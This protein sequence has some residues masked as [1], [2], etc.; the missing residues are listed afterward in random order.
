MAPVGM[1]SAVVSEGW[2]WEGIAFEQATR[3]PMRD[4]HRQNPLMMSTLIFRE[5]AQGYDEDRRK[6]RCCCC[7]GGGCCCGRD[8][9]WNVNGKEQRSQVAGA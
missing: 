9:G 3:G 8:G 2:R 5:A 4:E 1:V 6:G 7:F